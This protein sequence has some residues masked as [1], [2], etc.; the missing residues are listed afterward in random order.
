MTDTATLKSEQRALADDFNDVVADAQ[1]LLRHAAR[2][3]GEGYDDARQRLERSLKAMREQLDSLERAA[4]DKAK[5]AGRATDG[6]VHEHPWQAAGIGAGV[7]L[8]LGML[9]ARR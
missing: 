6:Y 2:D 1:A 3:A 9:I 5:S 4:V 8:L 7:G